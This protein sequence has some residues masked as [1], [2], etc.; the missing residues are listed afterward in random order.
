MTIF[1]EFFKKLM[2]RT[3]TGALIGFVFIHSDIEIHQSI[4]GKKDGWI[5]SVGDKTVVTTLKYEIF[6]KPL[7][8]EQC[9]W[10]NLKK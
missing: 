7:E 4:N 10:V 8:K 6:G 9:T 2:A 5:G 3:I 1:N